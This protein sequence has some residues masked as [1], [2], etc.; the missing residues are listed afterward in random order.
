MSIERLL[1]ELNPEQLSAATTA[2]HNALVLAGAGCGKTKTIVARAAYLISQGVAPDQIQIVTFTRRAASEIVTR[3]EHYLG[4]QA[5]GLHASTFHTFCMG[6]L[7]RYAKAFD[8]GSFNVIDRDDQ[9]MMLRLLRGK[10]AEEE[11][12]PKAAALL[13]VYS[14]TRNT[15]CKFDDALRKLM[16]DKVEQKAHIVDILKNYE[17]QKRERNYLDY[18]DILEYVAQ[19]LNQ[20]PEL[21]DHI[22]KRCR[23]LLV[24]EMQDTNPLQWLLLQPF[25]GK[26]DLFCVG[27][28]AQ[29]IY[30]FRGADF[31][32]IHGFADKVSDAQILTLAQNYRSTQQILDLSNWLLDRSPLHYNKRLQAVRGDGHGPILHTFPNEFEEAAWIAQDLQRRH[33]ADCAW[34]E[35]MILVRSSFSGRQIESALIAAD[36]PYQFIGGTKLLESAHVKDVLS[37]LRVVANFKDELAWMRFLTLWDGIGD[38]SAGRLVA[39]FLQLDSLD[40]CIARMTQAKK[41]PLDVGHTLR[42]LQSI[43]HQ[44][45]RCIE[46]ALEHLE[47]QLEKKYKNQ[48]WDKRKRDFV[49]VRQLGER[50]HN[51]SEF[52][53][54]YI[55]EPVSHSQI[56]TAA[57]REVVTLITI[58]S[59]KGTEREVCYVAH[60]CA[61]NFPHARSQ[62]D[63]DEVEEER[64]VLYVALTRAKNEL[65]ITR[66]NLSTW[67]KDQVDAQGRTIEAYFLSSL[68]HNLCAEQ[69]HSAYRSQQSFS[70]NL[71]SILNKP[72]IGID[73]DA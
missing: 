50:H 24:D 33:Q 46:V 25:I 62:G 48:D 66:Q 67:V 49:L 54:E 69:L 34:H 59:A 65:I 30:G 64:R 21:V 47:P 40:A 44:V 45:A 58:H 63:F 61:G 43:S 57:E 11:Q 7:R 2:A 71:S 12:L 51:I 73:W 4:V 56:E 31:S 39:N 52:I 32:N 13:D 29:S 36:I 72:N 1:N 14:Y 37:M 23:Y 19:Y 3:V 6:I 53:E 16:P 10:H 8:L 27:D 22:V 28:D 60:A 38:A 5:Q 26:S 18:D 42:Q 15:Q 35:H 68:P 55:L 20:S 70:S 17:Q 9:V 41:L